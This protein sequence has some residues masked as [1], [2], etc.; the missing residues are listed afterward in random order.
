MNNPQV[1]PKDLY[2]E[3]LSGTA[4]TAPR[5]SNLR[6]WLYRRLPSAKHLPWTPCSPGQKVVPSFFDEKHLRITPEQLRLKA[7][8]DPEEGQDFVASWVTL[9]GSGDPSIKNGLAIY[10]YST[11][12]SMAN[13]AFFNADGDILIVPH[14]GTLFL[15]TEFGKMTVGP[16]EI[17]V[18]P[19]GI[20]FQVAV[21]GVSKG[22]VSEIFK[23]HFKIPDL[24]PIG[25]NGL[26]NPRDF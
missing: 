5:H 9:A 17:A 19:R 11:Q 2:A 25:A 7:I 22:W 14:Q 4:F 10:S 13:H 26:A 1:C 21:R 16:R 18:V 24:G 12:T 15:T 8:P 6:S 20:V 23:G 3:Q